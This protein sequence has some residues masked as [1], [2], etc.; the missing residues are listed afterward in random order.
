MKCV[1]KNQA[2]KKKKSPQSP[3]FEEVFF[4][5]RQ[6]R[7]V[8]NGKLQNMDMPSL[9]SQAVGIETSTCYI[10]SST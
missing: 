7:S 8:V 9:K 3:I 1:G 2:Q 10:N 5:N 4:K 6:L